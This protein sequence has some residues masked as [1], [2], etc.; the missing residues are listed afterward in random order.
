MKTK[1]KKIGRVVDENFDEVAGLKIENNKILGT[2]HQAGGGMPRVYWDMS[3]KKITARHDL[4]MD[5]I[6]IT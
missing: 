2:V 3:G 6:E 4:K 5:N 1:I